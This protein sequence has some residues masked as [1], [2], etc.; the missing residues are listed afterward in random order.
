M[1]AS[2]AVLAQPESFLHIA[3]GG[4]FFLSLGTH[5]S[6]NF[7]SHEVTGVGAACSPNFFLH[8]TRNRMNRDRDGHIGTNGK[9]PPKD[10]SRTPLANIRDF[11][12]LAEWEILKSL[13]PCAPMFNL[14][15]VSLMGPRCK[16]YVGYRELPRAHLEVN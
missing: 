8:D 1:T 12:I 9:L 13:T 4:R 10:C 14:L 2:Q 3:K 15:H 6:F 5:E 16:P 11:A 7:R